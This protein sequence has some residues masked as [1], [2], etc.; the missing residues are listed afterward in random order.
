MLLSEGK[1]HYYCCY[2]KR[3][4]LLT[5]CCG[6]GILVRPKRLN[7]Q[8][9]TPSIDRMEK[10]LEEWRDKLHSLGARSFYVT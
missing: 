7:K 9:W 3:G 1:I 5:T 8:D 10:K 6:L 2:F 4:P